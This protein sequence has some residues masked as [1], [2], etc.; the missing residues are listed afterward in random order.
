MRWLLI[1][2]LVPGAAVAQDAQHRAQIKELMRIT[3][4]AQLGLQ[5]ANAVTQDM[6]RQLRQSRPDIPERAI[7]AVNQE[8]RGLFEERIDTLLERVVPVYEKHFS[9]AEI[10][11]LLAF[12]R[13]PTGRK[14]IAAMPAVM[15]ESVAIG[16]SWGRALAPEMNRRVRAALKRE[17]IE[18]KD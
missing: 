6:T 4:S 13:T 12:Y 2:L 10:N 7:A 14:A 3:G 9:P 1:I 5:F 8:V 15:G 11:D 17:G 16:Q 18:L